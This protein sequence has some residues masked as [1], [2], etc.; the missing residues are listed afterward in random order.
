MKKDMD[1]YKNILHKDS[2]TTLVVAII[3]A[4]INL[5]FIGS[6]NEA[7]VPIF[8]KSII[9]IVTS[10]IIICT[11]KETQKFIGTLSLITSILM[12]L[13][14]LVDSSLFGIVYFMLGIFLCIHSIKYLNNYKKY[15]IEPQS[16][17]K[18]NKHN[19]I[20]F[21]S[22]IPIILSVIL[23]VINLILEITN[24]NN[25]ISWCNILILILNILNITF[26][27]IL[28]HKKIKSAFIYIMLAISI[29][30]TF[31]SGLFLIDEI[32][33]KIRKNNYYDS[34]DFL[35]KY[36]KKA[37]EE[38][39]ED[40]TEAG[41]L[42]K[43]N[44][45][46]SKE[47]IITL[48]NFLNTISGNEILSNYMYSIKE[49]E[50]KGY[51]CNGYAILKFKDMADKDYYNLILN[52]EYNDTTDMSRF[53]DINTYISCS[54][55]HSYTTADFNE[56]I[57]NNKEEIFSI[58]FPE[59]YY[60]INSTKIE[61]DLEFLKGLGDEYITNA[62]IEKNTLVLEVTESQKNKL[63]ERN[64][65]FL[66]KYSNMFI[67][68]NENYHYEYNTDSNE[69]S[70]YFDENHTSS[71]MVGLTVTYGAYLMNNILSEREDWKINLKII[72]CDTNQLVAEALMPGE[73]LSFDEID[74]KNSY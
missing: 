57:I 19:K 46:I 48:D 58:I 25:T 17:E 70:F 26:C 34:E 72:N 73:E 44:I 38:L 42:K 30:I 39:Q 55:K 47:N 18:I 43:L 24:K 14:S 66:E 6:G 68:S 32:G 15:N 64:N 40:I 54:G 27:I 74:W 50:E 31:L 67:N 9:F 23:V 2:I 41:N 21:V 36:A 22:I 28:S 56:D 12:M 7:S 11:K 49:L 71:T 37:E 5:I 63:I 51:S 16:N 65:G 35:I 13:T 3:F 61:E 33:T 4:I 62:K 1:Y 52:K 8:L 53:F 60:G 45:D 29:L 69:L 20:K 10:T 59:S